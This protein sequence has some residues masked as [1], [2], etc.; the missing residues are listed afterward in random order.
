MMGSQHGLLWT[1]GA[2]GSLRKSSKDRYG[3]LTLHL[4]LPPTASLREILHKMLS[5]S[6]M[7]P[8]P[9]N[10]VPCGPCKDNFL[11]EDQIDL[12]KLPAPQ[13]HQADGVKCIKSYGMHIV[14]LP[15]G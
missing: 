14:Q 2:P 15:N 11:T 10:I 5:A 8:I 3:R 12:M 9:P 7:P 4:A 6:S 13:I 1:L